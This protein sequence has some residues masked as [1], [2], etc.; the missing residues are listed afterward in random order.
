M[1]HLG[2]GRTRIALIEIEAGLL[3][4]GKAHRKAIATLVDDRFRWR[5]IAAQ[6]AGALGQTLTLACI[7]IGAFV[8]AIDAVERHQ[9]I[10]NYV[11]PLVGRSGTE[12]Q[13]H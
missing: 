6:Q 9:C 1:S 3:A 5:L 11:A 7:D 12:L 8:D 2:N 10:C 13:H 4:F